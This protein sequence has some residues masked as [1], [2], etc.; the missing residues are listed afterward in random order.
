MTIQ[1]NNYFAKATQPAGN[2]WRTSWLTQEQ[3]TE[4]AKWFV[5][6]WALNGLPTAEA[7]VFFSN[8]NI[9]TTITR[10]SL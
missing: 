4:K 3:A 9:V 2:S 5:R 7:S 10:E 8:G 6:E 1:T